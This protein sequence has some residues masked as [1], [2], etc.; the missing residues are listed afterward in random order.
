MLRSAV[1]LRFL[2]LADQSSP[3]NGYRLQRSGGKHPLLL[4]V[5]IRR[6]PGNWGITLPLLVHAFAS[7]HSSVSQP[8]VPHR[9]VLPAHA[10]AIPGL[11]DLDFLLC[12]LRRFPQFPF[13]LGIQANAGAVIFHLR[14]DWLE[15]SVWIFPEA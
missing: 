5:R 7:I 9:L 10:I 3:H 13:P 15:T 8:L 11:I 12:T 1:A 6:V 14:S 4:T 2:A